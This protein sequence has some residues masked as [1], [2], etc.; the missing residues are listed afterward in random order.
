MRQLNVARLARLG[1]LILSGNWAI[2]PKFLAELIQ[3]A[4]RRG[5]VVSLATF[6]VNQFLP[7]LAL[8]NPEKATRD[9]RE[10]EC[11]FQSAWSGAGVHTFELQACGRV[12][13][14]R[15]TPASL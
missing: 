4:Q 12:P 5:D 11:L 14:L 13:S 1:G 7:M 8:D 9:L 3:D 2:L 6:Q 15:F 10:A